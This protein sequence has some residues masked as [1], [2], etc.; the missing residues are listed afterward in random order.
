MAIKTEGIIVR[1]NGKTVGC[2]SAIGA[3]NL[4]RDKTEKKCLDTGEIRTILDVIKTGDLDIE[5]DYD[6]TDAA[7]HDEL[8][9]V[10]DAGSEF[11]FE[12]ELSDKGSS[13]GT[14]FTWSKAVVS[15]LEINPDSDGEVGIK[16]TVAPGGK[17]T[18]TA[19]A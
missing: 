12:I 17:P 11:E 13:N 15:A 1:A 4:S 8:E 16:F 5:T 14:K 3:I 10:F 9:T 18:V 7:G 2:L 19:A 6:P